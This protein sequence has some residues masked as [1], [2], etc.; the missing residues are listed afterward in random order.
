MV[1]QLQ[2][3]VG[4]KATKAGEFHQNYMERYINGFTQGCS[5]PIELYY[6]RIGSRVRAP[7][8]RA[9]ATLVMP[10]LRM[11][12]RARLRA[13]AISLNETVFTAMAQAWAVIAAGVAGYDTA[14]PHSATGHDPNLTPC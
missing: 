12:L 6:T 10:L 11:G 2:S 14:G 7:L 4:G 13:W 9:C 1:C 8:Q 3:G 5:M